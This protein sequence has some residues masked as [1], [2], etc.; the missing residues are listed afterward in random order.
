MA[1]VVQYRLERMAEELDDLEHRG[2][3]EREK[4]SGI[5]KQRREFEYRLQRPSPLKQDFLA[6]IEYEKQLEAYRKCR[7][8]QIIRQ[9]VAEDHGGGGGEKPK[10]GSKWKKSISDFAGIRRILDLYRMAVVR[11]KGD[12]RLW[13]QYLEFC[14]ENGLRRMK[15]AL[16]QA[17][18]L[19]PKVPSLWIY[20][21]AWEFDRNLNVV[22]S[23]ALMQN[24][25]R[26]CP[27]SQDLWIEYLR[28]ELTYLNK[29]KARKVALGEDQTLEQ[30]CSEITQWKEENK[31]LFMS[32][33]AENNYEENEEE[34][35]V[36]DGHL[37]KQNIFWRLGSMILEAIYHEAIKAIPSSISLRKKFL[38]VLD[39]VDLAHSVELR[40]EILDDLKRDFLHDEICWDLIARL[41]I[42]DIKTIT[43]VSR[44]DMLSKLKQAFQCSRGLR[45]FDCMYVEL[46]ADRFEKVVMVIP[47]HSSRAYHTVLFNVYEEAFNVLPSVKMFSLFLKFWSNVTNPNSTSINTAVD[48]TEFHSSLQK[49]FEKA[50]SSGC[51]T[52]D[53]ACEYISFY[54]QAENLERARQEAKRLCGG[55]LSEAA[56]LW[57]L[58]ISIEIKCL[59][60]KA[61]PM[62]KDD[63]QFIFQLL[64]HVLDRLS[65]S[66]AQCLWFMALK[67]FSNDKVFFKKL[68]KVLEDALAR[69]GSNCETTVSSAVLDQA[70]QK[71]GIQHARDLYKR[72]LS[73]PHPGLTFFKHCIDLE[74]NLASLGEE[75]SLKNARW[76]YE[77]ALQLYC[78]EKEIWRDY[79]ALEM[80]AIL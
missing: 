77:S 71:G 16:G 61:A 64:K 18:K 3:I 23:R 24:G 25:L 68:V 17:L 54:L 21:A 72:F 12:L 19:H 57:L 30:G 60:N 69:S 80:K 65:V 37:E 6:Y 66:K 13:F 70:L 22:A 42:N 32:L 26:A 1:D 73:L 74:S 9:M 79:Y 38:E 44:H 39:S 15:E 10:R 75:D 35:Y 27:N 52:E 56:N 2:L 28:L 36:Q 4:I 11:F 76:L 34:L 45:C 62:N 49:A 59:T 29:L 7:K 58:R 51:L 48:V 47:D 31:D 5:V 63:L 46:H 8:R 40:L 50:E 43:A 41:H 53:L 55:K 20:A 14:R 67:L 78:Q 33:D